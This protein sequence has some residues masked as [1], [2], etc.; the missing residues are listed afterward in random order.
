MIVSFLGITPAYRGH[1]VVISAM[2]AGITAS[3]SG[4]LS[5]TLQAFGD[6]LA[7]LAA[8]ALVGMGL[9]FARA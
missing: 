8:A 5:I 4:G 6:Q 3:A 7:V 9:I 2:I 1:S